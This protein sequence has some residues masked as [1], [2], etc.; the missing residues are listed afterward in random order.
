VFLANGYL[1]AFHVLLK[2]KGLSTHEYIYQAK[3]PK[4]ETESNEEQIV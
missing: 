4:E 3:K 2:V 1:V